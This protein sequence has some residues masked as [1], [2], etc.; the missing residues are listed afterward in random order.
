MY[1]NAARRS[2]NDSF[3]VVRMQPFPIS[4]RVSDRLKSL[5]QGQHLCLFYERIEEQ[6]AITVEYLALGL[7]RG[8]RCL[9]VSDE[10]N[11]ADVRQQ[12]GWAKVDV[13]SETN[14]GALVLRTRGETYLQDGYFDPERMIASLNQ[15]VQQALNAGFKG[16]RAA[17]DMS[18]LL[19]K[20]PGSDEAM[21]YEALITRFY[22]RS[23]AVGLCLY[24]RRLLDPLVLEGAL[25]THPTAIVGDDCC[26]ANPFF[27]RPVA[28]RQE[29]D[30]RERFHAKL[31]M[32]AELVHERRGSASSSAVANG[33]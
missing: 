17:G 29:P 33:E 8:E 18:W 32:L 28:F 20:A 13:A 5:T 11:L 7:L 19:D 31:R 4:P 3:A 2:W 16:L 21:V 14:S 27:E 9:F 30:P 15:A 10:R 26:D 1:I 22:A 24:N 23:P 6:V 12:L 25:H